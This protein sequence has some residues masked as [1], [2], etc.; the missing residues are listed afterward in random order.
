MKS[1]LGTTNQPLVRWQSGAYSLVA[2]NPYWRDEVTCPATVIKSNH[3]SYN[4]WSYSV[5]NRFYHSGSYTGR[6]GAYGGANPGTFFYG[7]GPFPTLTE[8]SYLSFEDNAGTYNRALGKLN[9]KVR[10]SLDISVSV[11][12]HAATTKMLKN[13]RKSTR[14]IQ[15]V[16]LKRW[17]S[18]WLELQYGWLPLISD[19]YKAADEVINVSD[20]FMR[21]TVRVG[22]PADVSGDWTQFQHVGA[23]NAS[24]AG[25]STNFMPIS[26]FKAE[27]F[28]ACQLRVNLK[29][30]NTT[31]QLSRW[32]SLN[33]LSIA[34]ELMPYSF[35]VDWFYDVGSYLRD[36]ETQLLYGA[37]FESG[38]RSNLYTCD[39]G[40]R[41]KGYGPE[42]NYFD[43][44]TSVDSYSSCRYKKFSRT[45]LTSYPSPNR[46]R[47]TTNLSSGKMLNA[48]AILSQFLGS[49]TRKA[50]LL[51]KSVRSVLQAKLA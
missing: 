47:V 31:Q 38:F 29:K 40:N 14:Y 18:E 2:N 6:R 45:V 46:P 35:I 28:N 49:S 9:E 27:T 17:G 13:L 22:I 44:T 26:H 24:I 12:E 33:P 50:S 10:G 34:W 21:F 19:L 11:A 41:V 51:S 48:A 3:V 8:K 39:I 5:T 30:P 7:T 20:Q 36:T 23:N 1:R 42:V 32:S 25:I 43:K 15:S 16:G 4:A 37:L